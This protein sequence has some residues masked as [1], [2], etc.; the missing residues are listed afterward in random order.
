MMY[1]CGSFLI[2]GEV[3]ATLT[4]DNQMVVKESLKQA[5]RELREAEASGVKLPDARNLFK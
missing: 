3:M 4:I 2:K 5:F 1:F